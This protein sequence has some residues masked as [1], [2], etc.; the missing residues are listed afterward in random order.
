MRKII[1]YI[2][3]SIS[4]LSCK[5]NLPVKVLLITG[6]H[7]YDKEN[8]DAM[9]GKLP[10]VYDHLKHPDAHAALKADKIDAYDVVILYDMPKEIATE[11][12]QDFIAMLQKGKGLVVL[13]HAFC[14]Y[15]H[16]P[17]YVR[18]VGGRYHHYPW[19][20]DGVEQKPSTYA[21][22]I[23]LSVRVEDTKHP[24]TKG[25][26]DFKIIDEAYGNTE[27]RPDVHP[28]LS[29]DAS[30]SGPL[31]C[32]TNTYGK[33]RVVTLTLGHDKKAWEHP[34]FIQILSQAIAWAK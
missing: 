17:E 31:V 10:I 23:T 28:L 7:D 20:K 4:L 29:T 15:D 5:S 19:T 25:I 14:S 32:W 33:S 22:D 18:I 27:I 8:F 2:C 34:G 6:G 21:H 9:L 26:T 12:Q 30:E 3:L 11:A 13:H 16:W 24:V 1:F